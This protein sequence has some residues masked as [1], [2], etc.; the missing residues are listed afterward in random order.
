[1]D[2]SRRRSSRASATGAST[3]AGGGQQGQLPVAPAGRRASWRARGRDAFH[4]P[5]ESF[6]LR[7][8]AQGEL[9]ARE[10]LLQMKELP[11]D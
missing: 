6:S 8:L 1:M 5:N 10:L 3:R 11:R 7:S 9:A 4:A 2:G